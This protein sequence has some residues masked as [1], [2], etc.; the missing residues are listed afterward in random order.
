[1]FKRCASFLTLLACLGATSGALAENVVVGEPFPEISEKDLLTGNAITIEGLR[2]KVVVIDVWATWC[3]PCIA[4]L[5]NVREAYTAFHEKGMEIVSISLDSDV[6]KCKTYVEGNDMPW[7]HIAD[8]G[9]KA[10][11]AKRFG[12]NSI[13]RM[14]VLD[15]NGVVVAENVRGQALHRAIEQAL[16]GKLTVASTKS[17]AS[18]DDVEKAGVKALESADKLRKEKKYAEALEAY[19][20]I[21]IDYVGRDVAHKAGK[22]AKAIR[23]DKAIADE[24]AKSSSTWPASTFRR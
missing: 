21:M 18:S 13:P 10:K 19:E 9:G 7:L 22:S 1:M 8:G 23:S 16:A 20:Q 14:Y 5:P 15:K 24:L 4:E 6:E 2:G 11:L 17:P 12:I 3:G